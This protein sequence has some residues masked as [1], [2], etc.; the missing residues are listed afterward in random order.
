MRPMLLQYYEAATATIRR[1]SLRALLIRHCS[2]QAA[3]AI[4]RSRRPDVAV[5]FCVLYWFDLWAW[6]GQL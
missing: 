1:Y 3:Y 5:V 4:I 6:A 2:P